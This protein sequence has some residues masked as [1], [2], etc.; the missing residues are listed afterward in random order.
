LIEERL[1]NS[2]HLSKKAQY[3]NFE[4]LPQRPEK[5]KMKLLAITPQKT[6]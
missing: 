1:D 4:K 5:V 6:S 3:L 2:I